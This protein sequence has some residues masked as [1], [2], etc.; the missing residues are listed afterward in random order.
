MKKIIRFS[1]IAAV[2]VA[3]GY[4]A[5]SQSQKTETLSDL[6]LANVEALARNETGHHITC[7]S[8]GTGNAF[9]C[10]CGTCVWGYTS[11]YNKGTCF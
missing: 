7:Y 1:F 10:K 2:A 6:E 8:G 5:Y 11:T 9:M 3:A 4:T